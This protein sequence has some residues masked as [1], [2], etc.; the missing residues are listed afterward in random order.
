MLNYLIKITVLDNVFHQDGITIRGTNLSNWNTHIIEGNMKDETPIYYYQNTADSVIPYDAGQVLLANCSNMLIQHLNLSNVQLGFSSHNTISDNNITNRTDVGIYL[1]V[2]SENDIQGNIVNTIMR[3]GIEIKESLYN[4]IFGNSITNNNNGIILSDSS[5]HNII[6]GNNITNNY[7]GIQIEFATTNTICNNTISNHLHY[8][9]SI[10]DSSKNTVQGNNIS[11]TGLAAIS[12]R[13]SSYSII[14]ENIISESDDG[15]R[16]YDSLYIKIDRN[17]FHLGGITID[18]KS[19]QHWNTHTIEQNFVDEKQIRYYRDAI[20]GVVPSD[21][22]Q[23]ILANCSNM[24]IQHLNLSNAYCP[25][26]LGFSSHNTISDNSINNN[27]AYGIILFHSSNN[28]IF[29]NYITGSDIGIQVDYS[30]SNMI[31]KNT[32]L[33]TGFGIFIHFSKNNSIQGNN[34]LDNMVHAQFLNR[35][36]RYHNF[37][38]NTWRNNYWDDWIGIGPKIITGEVYPRSKVTGHWWLNFDWH[39]AKEPFDIQNMGE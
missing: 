22:G 14:T 37:R 16:L 7:C 6:S 39:P 24:L 27:D 21:A 15:I 4:T 12:M 11:N 31:G 23:V 10:Y 3:N 28:T 32:I 20:D 2:S 18:G 17:M 29:E 5:K 36:W 25:L 1:Y 35:A 26:Q 19:T 13:D 9:I 8:G 33:D 38:I 34:F 30:E